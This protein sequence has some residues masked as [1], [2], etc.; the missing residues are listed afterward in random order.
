MREK[1]SIF[2]EKHSKLD[3]S[4]I[5]VKKH[6]KLDRSSIIVEKH[7]ILDRIKGNREIH[8][9]RYARVWQMQL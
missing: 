8:G 5:I 9:P 6:S 3:R 2:V 7:S 4:S 1:N